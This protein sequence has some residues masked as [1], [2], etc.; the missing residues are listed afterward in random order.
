MSYPWLLII[1][2]I[3]LLAIGCRNDRAAE[4]PIED[5][6]SGPGGGYTS[7]TDEDKVTL[8][9]SCM[10]QKGF[11]FG[12]PELN[13]DSTINWERFKESINLLSNNTTKSYNL[14]GAL[15]GC[16]H[17]LDKVIITKALNKEDEVVQQ[18]ML[19]EYADCLRQNGIEL[20]DP[21]FYHSSRQ[22]MKAEFP[23]LDTPDKSYEMAANLCKRRIYANGDE[24]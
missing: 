18:D 20:D 11:A 14:K 5:G 16:Y 9:S 8:F 12:D 4:L 22:S 19:L 23:E 13:A 6:V 21:V 1:S 7:L 24:S 15:D 3:L 10:R 2:A 17:H